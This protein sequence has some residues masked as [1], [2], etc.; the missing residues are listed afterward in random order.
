M[1]ASE[2]QLMLIK[3]RKDKILFKQQQVIKATKKRLS[4]WAAE[5][6]HQVVHIHLLVELCTYDFARQITRALQY[7]EEQQELVDEER[8]RL[9]EKKEK[10]EEEELL[11]H[12]KKKKQQQKQEEEEEDPQYTPQAEELVATKMGGWEWKGRRYRKTKVKKKKEKNVN[13][14]LNKN[15]R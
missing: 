8:E 13:K 6:Q 5:R 2:K 4:F 7:E 1:K 15:F 11:L 10:E 9:E 14:N 3:K 12:K